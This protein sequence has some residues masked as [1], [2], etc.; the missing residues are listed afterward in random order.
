MTSIIGIN[1]ENNINF[2]PLKISDIKLM[3]YRCN[4]YY[5]L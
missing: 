3:I 1:E 5:K 4:I 2:H